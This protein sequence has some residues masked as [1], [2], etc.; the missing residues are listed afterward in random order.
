MNFLEFSMF[1][2]KYNSKE[3]HYK[4]S[5]VV[6]INCK[7]DELAQ[8]STNSISKDLHLYNECHFVRISEFLK[9]FSTNNLQD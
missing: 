2:E 4:K 8:N 6:D 3:I 7:F 1:D 5:T 9:T